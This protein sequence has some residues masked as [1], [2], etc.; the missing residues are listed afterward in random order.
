LFIGAAETAP[1]WDAV[2][3]LFAADTL[4]DE[5]RRLLL[6]GRSADGLVSAGQIVCACFSVGMATIRAAIHA[7]AASAEAIGEALRAGT[8]CG[9]CLPELKQLLADARLATASAAAATQPARVS[10]DRMHMPTAT[11]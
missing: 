8:N 5:T 3:T 11:P 2:K 9:S 6:S 10:D 1:Q 7:G 4:A